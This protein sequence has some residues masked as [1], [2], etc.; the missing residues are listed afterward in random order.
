MMTFREPLDAEEVYNIADASFEGSPWTLS[1]FE[2]DLANK[3]SQYLVIMIDNQPIGFASGVLIADELSIGHVAIIKTQQGHGL[4]SALLQEW[5]MNFPVGTR[6][7]L[8]VRSGNIAARKLYEKIG[9]RS[10]Y[11]RKDYYHDPV[12]DAVMMEFF[13]AGKESHDN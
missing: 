8:E 9:F 10:Y 7:L 6:A 5:L 4:G 13:T 12:E 3:W 1:A 11:V 2:T